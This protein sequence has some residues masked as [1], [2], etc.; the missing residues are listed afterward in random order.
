MARI[1]VGNLPF[2]ANEVTIRDLFALHGA[3]ETVSLMSDLAT[4]KPRGFGYVEMPSDDAVRAVAA[5]NG[6]DLSGSLIKVNAAEDK[7]P[8]ASIAQWRGR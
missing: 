5:L 3:V 2:S 1:F 4:G 7:P 8:V 6:H